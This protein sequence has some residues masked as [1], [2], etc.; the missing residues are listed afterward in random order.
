MKYAFYTLGCKVNQYETQAMQQLL[1]ARGDTLGEFDGVCDCYI[2]N[3]CTVT[4]VSDKKSRN[5]IRRARK[6]NPNAVIGVCGCYAQTAPEEIRKL[7]VDVLIGT[8]GRAEFLDK[9]AAAAA[10]KLRWEHVED[11]GL[12]RAFEQLPSGG[13]AERTRALLKVEDGCNNF[14]TYCIIPYAR[15]R[16]RSL[17]LENAVA[18][19]RKLAAEGYR[20]IVVN[21]I[22]ISSWGWEWHDGSCLRQLLAALCAAVPSVRIRLGSLEPRTIDEEFCKTLSGFENLCPQFHLSLQSGSDSVLRRMHRKYDSAR[23]LQSVELLHRYFPGCAVTTDLIVGFPGETEEE[24]EASLALI[25]RCALSKVH[26]FP[27]SRREG[28]PAAKMPDQVPKAIKEARA[29]RAAAVAAEL[30]DAFHTSLI[31]TEQPVLF[32]QPEN[33]FYAGHAPNYAKVYTAPGELHNAV[34]RVRITELCCDGVFGVLTDT[35]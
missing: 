21:G 28:T 1:L 6:L 4:A 11:A 35:P 13:L 23:Y 34:R 19:A 5:A 22:E 8:D 20:E 10:E 16:V 33:G 32:E 27:Y 24:F 15:G 25:R 12:P 3:T 30:E 9:L 17:P 14:C 18:E 2:V 31:G 7:D 26:I 29:S